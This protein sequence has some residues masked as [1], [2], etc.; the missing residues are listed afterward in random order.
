MASFRVVVVIMS[1]RTRESLSCFIISC[2]LIS[3]P[4]LLKSLIR[5]SILFYIPRSLSIEK[6]RRRR[7]KDLHNPLIV[8]CTNP[9][10]A[11]LCLIDPLSLCVWSTL[12]IVAVAFN[13]TGEKKWNQLEYGKSSQTNCQMRYSTTTNTM[14]NKTSFVVKRYASF[15]ARRNVS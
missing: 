9:H 1:S 15:C 12:T 2:L 5:Y 13:I 8:L 14:T 10:W 11:L 4:T 6:R 7:K 3:C